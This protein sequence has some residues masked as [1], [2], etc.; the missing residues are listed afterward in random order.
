MEFCPP[1]R[2]SIAVRQVVTKINTFPFL[3]ETGGYNFAFFVIYT[4]NHG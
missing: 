4:P 2:V 1:A 3:S